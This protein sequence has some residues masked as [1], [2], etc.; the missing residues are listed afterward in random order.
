MFGYHDE[1]LSLV[2]DILLDR[3]P[4]IIAINQKIMNYST[5]LL[6]KDNCSIVKQDLR[7]AGEYSYYS[8]IISMFDL[9]TV[10]Y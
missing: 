7:H 10:L 8:N 4:P 5:Y 9:T 6:S 3:F 1:I 2:F